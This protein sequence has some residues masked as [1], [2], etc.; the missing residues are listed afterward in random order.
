MNN[1]PFA[2]FDIDIPKKYQEDIKRFCQTGGS[3]G[4]FTIAPF[5]RQVDFWYLAFVY[6]VNKGLSPKE[7][8]DTYHPIQGHILSDDRVT[9]ILLVYYSINAMDISALS[10]YRKA[11]NF[12]I[13]MAN[14]GIPHILQILKDSDGDPLW[15]LLD[16]L[17]VLCE[18]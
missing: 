6:A 2:G 18:E 7:E 13:N 3:G 4:T 11:F 9:H 1:N 12:A 10:E 14:A 15:N 5:E 16:E 17:E 8:N